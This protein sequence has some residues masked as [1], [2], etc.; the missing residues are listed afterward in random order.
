VLTISCAVLLPTLCIEYGVRRGWLSQRCLPRR[1]ER[2]LPV[3]IAIM[4]VLAAV[5]LVHRTG[6]DHKLLDS[7]YA[8]AF[9][10]SN[11]L[12]VTLVWKISLH[13]AALAG[14]VVIIGQ[15]VGA[16]CLLLVP[17]VALVAWSRV[18]LREHTLAQV[19]GGALVGVLGCAQAY[20]LAL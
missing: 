17:F 19:G 4:S 7:L 16:A 3:A 2:A 10:L 13:V 12:G 9:V 20:L 11:A 14:A 6:G 15:L 18:E 1:E 8:M 5:L